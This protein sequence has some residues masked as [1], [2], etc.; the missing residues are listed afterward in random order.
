MTWCD[1]IHFWGLVCNWFDWLIDWLIDWTST[2]ITNKTYKII[3]VCS[4]P[5][6]KKWLGDCGTSL[7]VISIRQ[8][9]PSFNFIFCYLIFSSITETIF[10]NNSDQTDTKLRFNK[11][12]NIFPEFALQHQKYFVSYVEQY[13]WTKIPLPSYNFFPHQ[14][15]RV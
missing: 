1:F 2:S 13:H 9:K 11:A 12:N 14:Q 6:V 3:D 7:L 5:I 10:G 4:K 8:F 15:E